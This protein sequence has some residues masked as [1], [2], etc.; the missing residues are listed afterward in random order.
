MPPID[1]I[2]LSR[3]FGAGGSRLAAALGARL[4]WPVLD[5][6]IAPTVAARLGVA[7]ETVAGCDEHAPRLLERMG[8]AVLWTSPEVGVPLELLQRPDPDTVAAATREL[9]VEAAAAPPRVLVGH[10]AQALLHDRPGTLHLRLVAPL[11]DRVRRIRA[12]TGVG[13]SEA[14]ALAARMDA[15]RA[16]YVRHYYRR[17][18]ADP[19]LYDLALNTGRVGLDEALAIVEALVRGGGAGPDAR[20]DAWDEAAPPAVA[21]AAPR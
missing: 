4:G 12:R 20:T 14:A 3:E 8:T 7:G 21:A 9:L 15:E 10:G 5:H 1:V 17:D 18:L 16:F 11:A 13:A 19:L 2:T 6:E